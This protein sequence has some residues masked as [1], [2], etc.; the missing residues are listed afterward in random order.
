M[1]ILPSVL[2]ACLSAGVPAAFAAAPCEPRDLGFDRAEAG[3]KHQP[4]S[5]LKRDTA[6]SV[7]EGGRPGGPAR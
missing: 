2:A 6:Y 3:W 4:M 1:R 7:D 5:K